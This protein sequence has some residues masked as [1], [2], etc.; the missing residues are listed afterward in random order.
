[1]RNLRLLL[2]AVCPAYTITTV[3]GGGSTQLSDGLVATDANIGTPSG[4]ALDPITGDIYFG[5]NNMILKLESS[6][7]KLFRIA[8][9]SG[10]RPTGMPTAPVKATEGFI[11]GTWGIGLHNG[12][13][14]FT[15]WL[16]YDGVYH[17]V[18]QEIDEAGMM[19]LYA[20]GLDLP[21]G[22]PSFDSAGNMYVNVDGGSGKIGIVQISP[23]ANAATNLHEV[24]KFCPLDQGSDDLLIRPDGKLVAPSYWSQAVFEVDPS[25]CTRTKLA[26]GLG[27]PKGA[28]YDLLGNLLT[29]ENTIRKV[30]RHT[31]TGIDTIAG[32]GAQR[33]W[34]RDT[35]KEVIP[36]LGDGGLAVAAT[37]QDPNYARVFKDGSIYITDNGHQRI[38]KL[39]CAGA[40]LVNAGLDTGFLTGG[41]IWLVGW[42]LMLPA[43]S[44]ACQR[45]T[46]R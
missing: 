44:S 34:D 1:M 8:G 43:S 37:L 10:Q 13:I 42:M 46:C 35:F 6:T 45:I 20:T 15:D 18:V 9:Q 25:T 11:Q 23:T 31:S 17:G 32:S 28:T 24:T 38:R 40:L 22:Q 29:V 4:V 41:L 33:Y 36:P 21:R 19:R 2:R 7:N 16:I 39:T 3:A 30:R 5:T 14:Y 27:H 26:E 12:K